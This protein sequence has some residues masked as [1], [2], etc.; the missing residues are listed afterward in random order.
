VNIRLEYDSLTIAELIQEQEDGMHEAFAYYLGLSPEKQQRCTKQFEE[1]LAE[2]K[3]IKEKSK[4][5]A[6]QELER[7]GF[8]DGYPCAA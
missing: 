3:A 7:R 8:F 1:G 5:L 4:A 2:I 6:R